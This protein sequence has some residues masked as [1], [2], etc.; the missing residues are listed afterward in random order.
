M[1]LIVAGGRDFKD[2]K[3]LCK[4]L[5]N[6]LQNTKKEDIQIVC[7][8]ARGADDLG[9]DYGEDRDIDVKIFE[10]DWDKYGRSAGYKRNVEMAKYSTHCVL[11]W[12]GVSKGTKHMLDLA[13]Q[14]GL[15]LRVYRY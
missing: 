9:R 6:L 3:R 14:Y 7:G 11:F 2:Y 8:G 5:D 12:D 4:I 1:K 10:A 15:E 13:K